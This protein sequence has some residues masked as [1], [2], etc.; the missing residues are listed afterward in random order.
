VN[1]VLNSDTVGGAASDQPKR[2]LTWTNR[3]RSIFALMLLC[4]AVSRCLSLIVP[5]TC[6]GLNDDPAGGMGYRAACR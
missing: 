5:H 1:D 3:L 4:A 2:R 6:R